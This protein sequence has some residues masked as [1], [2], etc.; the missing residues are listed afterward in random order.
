MTRWLLVRHGQTDW[1]VRGLKQG[2]TDVPLNQIGRDQAERLGKRLSAVEIDAAYCS[3]LLRCT[4]TLEAALGAREVAVSFS[5]LLREQ[6][7]GRWEG[8][9]YSEIEWDEP[10][11][12]AEMISG[13]YG[14]SPPGGESFLGVH[15][16]AMSFADE[17]RARH[18]S[19]TLL[20]VGHGAALRALIA[21]L[22]GLRLEMTWRF[23]VDS[24][25]ITILDVGADTAALELLND[26]SHLRRGM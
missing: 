18:P 8:R 19:G 3:D 16:R 5:K 26:T 21:S 15:A 9:S 7:Y 23:K 12:Y 4:Q 10:D 25:S 20:V 24:C 2:H 6:A 1:N 14:F 11:L 17:T 22:I 13:Y